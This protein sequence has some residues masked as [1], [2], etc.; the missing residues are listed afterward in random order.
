MGAYNRS[1]SMP[2]AGAIIWAAIAIVATQV[3]EPTSTLILLF[4]SGAIFPVAL[5]IAR[6]RGENLVSSSNPLAKLIGLSILMVNLLW[7][8]HI[9]LFIYSPTF[10]PLS[11]GVGLGLHW[12]I[13]S[14][15]V[16]HPVGIIHAVLRTVL[17][18]LAWL[19]FPESRLLVV[20]IVVVFVYAVSIYQMTTR[21]IAYT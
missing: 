1:L 17:I 18:L 16:Q 21:Q 3:S 4:A 12:I 13:Y 15:I 10:V 7:A 6:F 14:W 2:L 20:S 5:V 8:I 11:L 19:A 9:P